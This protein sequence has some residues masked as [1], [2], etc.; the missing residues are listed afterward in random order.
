M[1]RPSNTEERKAQIVRGMLR[2]MAERGYERATVQAIADAADLSPGL[3]H[4]HFA[5]KQEILVALAEDLARAAQDRQRALTSRRS[6]RARLLAFLDAHV[7]LGQGADPA[8]VACWVAIGAEALRIPDV[9]AVYQRVTAEVMRALEDLAREAL[10]EER[11]VTRRARAIAAG[12]LA[13]AEG[14]FQLSAAAPGLLPRGFAAPTLRA[15]AAG[16]LDAQ[17]LAHAR[18]K[19]K[20]KPNKARRAPQ[21]TSP[22]RPIARARRSRA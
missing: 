18:P 16:L 17:P 9:Q 6:A 1:S 19:S 2:V 4:Y 11:R 12:L 20:A 22:A 14:A 8:A 15:M 10:R 5:S 13:A 21:T 3:L 7:A